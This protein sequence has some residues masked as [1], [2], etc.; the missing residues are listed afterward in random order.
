MVDV[1]CAGWILDGM[2][3]IG[4]GAVGEGVEGGKGRRLVVS[5][6]RRKKATSL[7]VTWKRALKG[8]WKVRRVETERML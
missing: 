6:I 8:D 7:K 1:P 2:G 3:E 4:G 5:W